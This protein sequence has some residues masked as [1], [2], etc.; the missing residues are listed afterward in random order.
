MKIVVNIDNKNQLGLKQEELKDEKFDYA[1]DNQI[2]DEGNAGNQE[3][4]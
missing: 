1:Q 3:T 2:L 4:H